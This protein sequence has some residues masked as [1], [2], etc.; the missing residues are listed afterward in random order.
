MEA[1]ETAEC[2]QKGSEVRM[3]CLDVGAV[4]SVV[5]YCRVIFAFKIQSCNSSSWYGS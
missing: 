3:L 1:P 2:K 5:L 4:C